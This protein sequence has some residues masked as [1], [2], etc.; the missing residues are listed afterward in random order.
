[1]AKE[2]RGVQERDWVPRDKNV[3]CSAE[4]ANRKCGYN[5]ANCGKGTR[6]DDIRQMYRTV[7]CMGWRAVT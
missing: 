6:I 2:S 7:R 4:C 1:M 5:F 3:Y